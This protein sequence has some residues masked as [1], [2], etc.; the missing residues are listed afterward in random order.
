[1]LETAQRQ[2]LDVLDTIIAYL[3]GLAGGI[4]VLLGGWLLARLLRLLLGRLIQTLNLLLQRS[5][6]HRAGIPQSTERLLGE[7]VFWVTL[8]VSLTIAMR[9]AGLTGAASWLDRLVV[10]LP[11]LMAGG[12]II[13]VGFV[14]GAIARNL[15][16]HA[17]AA[18]DLAQASLLGHAVQTVFILVGLV[19]GLGQIGVD[20]SLLVIV[21]AITLAALLGGIAL[22]FGLGTRTLVENLVAVRHVRLLV[23]PGQMAEIAGNRGR[24]LEFTTTGLILETA[25]GRRL[26]PASLCLREPMTLITG[27]SDSEN[28]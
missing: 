24:V 1:M 27:D 2:T 25:E 23:S 7:T 13:I 18:A 15:V 17:A 3:P 22:A 4:L 16:N 14:A 21:I 8:L 19:I 9:L 12:L 6:L 11:S 28:P 10:F 26:I 20:V 5:V